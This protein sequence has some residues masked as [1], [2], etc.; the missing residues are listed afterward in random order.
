MK[1]LILILLFLVPLSEKYPTKYGRPTPKGIGMY[2]EDKWIDLIY[3]YQD[4]IED[5]LWLDV[6]I[7][8]E[9]LTD[10]V[11]HDSLELGRYE[12]D[13]LIYIDQDTNFIAYELKPL[14]R[15]RKSTIGESNKFVKGVVFHELTH[16][17]MNQ[18]GKEMEYYDSVRVD[19]SYQTGIWIIRNPNM[20][21]S[22]FIEEGVCEYMV[23]KMGELIPP[24]KYRAPKTISDLTSRNNKYKYIYKYSSFYLKTFLDTTGFKKGVKI[25]MSNEPPRYEEILMPELFFNRLEYV[26]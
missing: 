5:T 2:I 20:F 8:A 13:G 12:Y 6:W 23:S 24:K 22:M 10:Y 1:S 16:H 11:G 15:F 17:Y 21:G 4:F 14:S 25:L 26:P 18:I 3:E 19:R 9:N 7:E